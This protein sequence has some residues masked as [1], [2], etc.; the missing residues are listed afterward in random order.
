MKLIIIRHGE[1]EEN[2]QG[3]IQGHLPGILS[4]LGIEQAKK[5]A[6]RL[7]EEKIDLIFSSD[8][9]RAKH[10]AEEIVRFHPEAPFELREDLRERNWGKFEGKRKDD[11][12]YWNEIE[13]KEVW[14]DDLIAK[15]GGETPQKTIKRI[16][17]FK[18]ELLQNFQGKTILIITHGTIGNFLLNKL[19]EENSKEKLKNT[20]I[21]IFEFNEDGNPELKLFNC[22]KHLEG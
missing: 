17:S 8:L 3:I 2:K 12:E 14:S 22:V 9:D 21:T 5:L 10:T 4:K 11:I 18:D 19:M 6:K 16:I 1:T 15:Y 13:S 7:K 20:S